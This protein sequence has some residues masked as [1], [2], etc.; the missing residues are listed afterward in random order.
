M[1]P[2]PNNAESAIFLD[3]RIFRF[4]NIGIGMHT[5]TRSVTKLKMATSRIPS[6]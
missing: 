2:N 3:L 4:H 1:N 5:I 6:V